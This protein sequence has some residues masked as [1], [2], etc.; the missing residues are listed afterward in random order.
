MPPEIYVSDV[1]YYTIFMYNLDGTLYGN[2]GS[3]GSG[4]G[5]F[6][7]PNGIIAFNKELYVADYGNRRLQIFDLEGTYK[8]EW[9]LIHP[10]SS[11]NS[12]PKVIVISDGEIFFVSN[13][14]NPP[15]DRISVYTLDGVFKRSWGPEYGGPDEPY[16][17]EGMSLAGP[18]LYTSDYENHRIR[19]Y[20]RYGTIITMFGSY[21][22]GNGQFQ[23]PRRNT[24][25]NN[26]LYVCDSV[27]HRIQIF[28]LNG[29]FKR[30]WGEYGTTPGKLN[31]PVGISVKGNIV[32]V[33]CMMDVEVQ[34]FDKN[35]VFIRQYELEYGN[36][37]DVYSPGGGIQYLPIIGMG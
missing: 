11:L 15:L 6:H 26:E 23:W 9:P 14:F 32:W 16:M 8:R 33:T 34:S 4:P 7:Y 1:Y 22:T 12:G 30:K 17:P 13:C 2:F 20:D 10:S 29:T 27:N 3:E 21:G 37:W 18:Y 5:E 35:G 28:D 19:V 36:P 31:T 25:N 24:I